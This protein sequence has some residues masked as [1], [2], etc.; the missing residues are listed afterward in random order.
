[1]SWLLL[2]LVIDSSGNKTSTTVS[3][4]STLLSCKVD[5]AYYRNIENRIQYICQRN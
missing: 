5:Q 3:T 2:L 1:M 4:H